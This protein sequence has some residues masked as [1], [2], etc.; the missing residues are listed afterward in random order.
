VTDRWG[1]AIEL[2]DQEVA[3]SLP[4]GT[5]GTVAIYTQSGKPV[6]VISKV[7]MRMNAWLAYLTS[8]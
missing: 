6:H 5:G 1:V 4:Q 8:P 3:R 2:D 7:A